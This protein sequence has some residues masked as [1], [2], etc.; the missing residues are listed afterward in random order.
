MIYQTIFKLPTNYDN[1]HALHGAV[2]AILTTS[3]TQNRNY[4]FRPFC[5][6]GITWIMARSTENNNS[7]YIQWRED[8][9]PLQA[10]QSIKFRLKLNPI[11][12]AEGKTIGII[13]D[14][15]EAEIWFKKKLTKQGLVVEDLCLTPYEYESLKRIPLITQDCQARCRIENEELFRNAYIH[16]IGKR[17]AYGLGMIIRMPE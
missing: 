16:G 15:A 7:D 10:G 4:I 12:R 5:R 11:H 1:L 14:Q 6:N 2:Q 17:K 3:P 8:A 9:S 13:K